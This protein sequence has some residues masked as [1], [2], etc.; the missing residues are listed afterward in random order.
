MHGRIVPYYIL[1]IK[2]NRDVVL[3]IETLARLHRLRFRGY[4]PA[5]QVGR[6]LAESLI[7]DTN[8]SF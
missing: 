2:P 3:L 4:P 6:R 7:H 1:P 8:L 5:E